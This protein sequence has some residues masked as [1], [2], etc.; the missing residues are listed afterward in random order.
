MSAKDKLGSFLNRARDTA[1]VAGSQAGGLLKVDI[2]C[3]LIIDTEEF[4]GLDISLN[5]L[6]SNKFNNKSMLD[7]PRHPPIHP[8]R[9]HLPPS[10]P[11]HQR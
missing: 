3:R 5:R 8:A 11:P 1:A 6:D 7:P 9:Q 4:Q 10:L 2:P